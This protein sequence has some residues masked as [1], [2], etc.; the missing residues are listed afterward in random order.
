MDRNE[1]LIRD[2]EG[3]LVRLKAE[4][5]DPDG[6]VLYEL[7]AEGLLSQVELLAVAHEILERFGSL[8]SAQAVARVARK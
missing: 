8:H 4:A 6:K 1:V 7:R 5:S 2:S 3:S